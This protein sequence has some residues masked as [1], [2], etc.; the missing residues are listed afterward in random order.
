[1]RIWTKSLTGNLSALLT[2]FF[3]ALLNWAALDDIGG[4]AE[5]EPGWLPEAEQDGDL[6]HQ[7]EA[8]VDEET[9]EFVPGTQPGRDDT[10]PEAGRE[11]CTSGN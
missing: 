4:G 6:E 11:C 1:M 5:S 9:R 10:P 7:E 2:T 3:R 8:E